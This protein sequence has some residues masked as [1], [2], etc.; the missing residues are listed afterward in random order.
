VKYVEANLV[1]LMF[2]NR[3]QN[4]F[5]SKNKVLSAMKVRYDKENVKKCLPILGAKPSTPSPFR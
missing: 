4:T 3:L 2:A 5:D 1:G